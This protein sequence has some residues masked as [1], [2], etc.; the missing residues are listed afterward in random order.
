MGNDDI[1]LGGSGN[2]QLYGGTGNDLLLGGANNDLLYGESGNDDLWGGTGND[3]YIGSISEIG[4]DFINDDKSA[5]GQTGYGGGNDV[6]KFIDT[7]IYSLFI[8]QVNG[9]D[10]YVG[11]TSYTKGVV[12]EDFFQGGNNTIEILADNYGNQFDLTLFLA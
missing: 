2:D 10:L 6:V 5:T 12:I 3:T 11:N 9:D 4:I 1:L 8:N 7:D